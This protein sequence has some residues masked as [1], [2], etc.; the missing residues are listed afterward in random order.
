MGEVMTFE[1]FQLF[2]IVILVV[3]LVV[4]AHVNT[5]CK[6]LLG[7]VDIHR[8]KIRFLAGTGEKCY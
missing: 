1:R 2:L 6:R 3:H 7:D 8:S 5:V 4:V